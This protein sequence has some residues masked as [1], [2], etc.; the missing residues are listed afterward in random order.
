MV[1]KAGERVRD[2]C[3]PTDRNSTDTK[4]ITFV[5]ADDPAQRNADSM[6]ASSVSVSSYEPCFVDSLGTL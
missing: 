5:C 6:F 2:A 3:S 1:S 4:L